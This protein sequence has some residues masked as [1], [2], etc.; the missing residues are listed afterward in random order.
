MKVLMVGAVGKYA[1][2]VLPEIKKRSGAVRA[3]IRDENRADDARKQG[4][5][6]VAIGDLNKPET[7]GGAV[8]GVDAVFHINPAFQLN[9]ADM[10]VAM[11]KR[12]RRRV[13]PSL[14]SRA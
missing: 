10:G 7:L 12:P 5:N 1:S 3:L 13:C 14:F 4:A 9:E 2:L 6:E 11:V 8:E